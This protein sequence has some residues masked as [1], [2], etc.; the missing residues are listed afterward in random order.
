[1]SRNLVP[2]GARRTL[3][4]AAVALVIVA[5]PIAV[6]GPALASPGVPL[7]PESS[8]TTSADPVHG[9]WGRPGWSRPGWPRPGGW[10]HHGWG[11]NPWGGGGWNPG[12]MYSPYGYGGMY[13][14]YGYGG[15]STGSAL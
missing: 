6:A 2:M 3:S 13:S 5:T 10:G 8:A 14:P 1:M 4:R 7:T 15:L 9:G 12:G 11:R